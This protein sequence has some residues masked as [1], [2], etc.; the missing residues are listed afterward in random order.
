MITLDSEFNDIGD[1]QRSDP[2][3]S[4]VIKALEEGRVPKGLSRQADK[5]FLK[6]GILCR[7]YRSQLGVEVSQLVVPR[8]LNSAI[9]KQLHDRGGHLGVSKTLAKVKERYYWPGYESAL[10]KKELTPCSH[11]GTSGYDFS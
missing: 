8:G 10:S 1:S 5:L 9:L 4:D 7:K 11:K 6:D 2:F 3:L